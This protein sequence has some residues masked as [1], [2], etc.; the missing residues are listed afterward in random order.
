MTD[1]ERGFAMA[2]EMAAQYCERWPNA[3]PPLLAE[4]IRALKLPPPLPVDDAGDAGECRTC[5]GRAGLAAVPRN[6]KTRSA[7]RASTAAAAERSGEVSDRPN[8]EL[9]VI[10]DRNRLLAERDA[11]RA[12]LAASQQQL[13]DVAKST[14]NQLASDLVDGFIAQ[15]AASQA[16]ERVMREA[17]KQV[18]LEADHATLHKWDAPLMGL[19]L[20]IEDAEAALATPADTSALRALL[21]HAARRGRGH[22][23]L[24]E[25]T[26]AEVD[27]LVVDAVLRGER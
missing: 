12:Q 3:Y 11:L 27:E 25:Q 22:L 16:R 15:A 10:N 18:V 17:L 23:A 14:Q 1:L 20:A 26:D 21:R 5:G 9:A 13:R 4:Q 6:A 24:N 19:Q 8:M 7:T 2:L